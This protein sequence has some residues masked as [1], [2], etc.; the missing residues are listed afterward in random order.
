MNEN[1]VQQGPGR[2]GAGFGATLDHYF[3]ISE[4]GSTVATEIRAGITT[5]LTM[6]LYSVY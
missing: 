5:F 2:S 4:R 1:T 3:K 6:G